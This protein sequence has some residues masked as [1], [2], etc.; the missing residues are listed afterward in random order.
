[1]DRLG[2]PEE[3]LARV[4]SKIPSRV[5]VETRELPEGTKCQS[6]VIDFLP[7]FSAPNIL[8]TCLRQDQA[9]DIAL[10]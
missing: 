8:T 9:I 1:M 6:V 4:G 10:L 3:R 5:C 7:T 2:S